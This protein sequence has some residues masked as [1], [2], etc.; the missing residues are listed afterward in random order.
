MCRATL[1]RV[2]SHGRIFLIPAQ[3]G[4]LIAACQQSRS[5]RWVPAPLTGTSGKANA[6]DAM[7]NAVSGIAICAERLRVD[8]AGFRSDQEGGHIDDLFGRAEPLH[9]R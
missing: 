1:R 2:R 5:A 4:N 9:R 3:A 6:P 8:P 7:T